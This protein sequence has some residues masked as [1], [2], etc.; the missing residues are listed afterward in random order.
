MDTPQMVGLA[1]GLGALALMLIIIFFKS[2]VVLCQ[3]NELVVI[4]GRQRQLA[5]GTRVGYRVLRGG[6]G[7]KW[8]LVRHPSDNLGTWPSGVELNGVRS[9]RA[10][11]LEYDDQFVRTVTEKLMS[12]ALGR[13]LEY[14][15][16]P[17]VR[18]IVREAEDNEYRWSSIV[19][20]IAKS[21]AFLMR[22]SAEPI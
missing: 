4:T 11:L 21:P 3:P 2:N 13:P 19:L 10:L 20:G 12:Y 1:V 14:F 5:D 17:T 15:D 6:R 18:Q 8:P 9:L 22:R 16:Q 7:F